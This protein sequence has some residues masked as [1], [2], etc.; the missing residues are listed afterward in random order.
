[1][2]TCKWEIILYRGGWATNT[3]YTC[4]TYYSSKKLK[5]IKSVIRFLIKKRQNCDYYQECL[6]LFCVFHEKEEG[7]KLEKGRRWKKYI[8]I[9][10]I[11]YLIFFLV[12]TSHFTYIFSSHWAEEIINTIASLVLWIKKLNWNN[13]S[14]CE[15]DPKLEGLLHFVIVYSHKT[16]LKHLTIFFVLF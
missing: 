4:S 6:L 13:R 14:M 16:W 7:D 11:F 12:I 15:S 5:T 8:Y 9:Y 1:M 3:N 10:I 2:A